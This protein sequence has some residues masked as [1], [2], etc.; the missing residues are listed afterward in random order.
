MAYIKAGWRRQL[1]V[2]G[3]RRGAPPSNGKPCDEDFNVCLHRG[4]PGGRLM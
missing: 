4:E 2:A 3:R 1:R